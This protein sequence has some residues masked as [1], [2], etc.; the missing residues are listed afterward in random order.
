MNIIFL[1]FL[2]FFW[3]LGANCNKMS[4]LLSFIS[5]I[6]SNTLALFPANSWKLNSLLGQRF[7]TAVKSFA[8]LLVFKTFIFILSK[9]QNFILFFLLHYICLLSFSFFAFQDK[10]LSLLIFSFTSYVLLE[11][12]FLYFSTKIAFH[13]RWHKKFA[14]NWILTTLLWHSRLLSNFLCFAIISARL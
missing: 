7:L 12:C 11:I 3:T 13:I 1:S 10:C 9:F 4:L 6:T 14:V 2:L 5:I 8:C